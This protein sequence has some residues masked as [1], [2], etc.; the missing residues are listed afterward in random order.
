MNLPPLNN[1]T[2]LMPTNMDADGE[3]TRSRRFSEFS[4]DERN[5]QEGLRS[6]MAVARNMDGQIKT[7]QASI[8]S[9]M[10]QINEFERNYL[11]KRQRHSG[12]P[13]DDEEPPPQY[14]YGAWGYGRRRNARSERAAV[15]DEEPSGTIRE[16]P[17][18]NYGQYWQSLSARD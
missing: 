16:V 8:Q 9:L 6:L 12:L 17:L 15:D 1:V 7:M 18:Q 3:G 10:T 5:Y 14:N 2:T 4:G 11:S 13:V